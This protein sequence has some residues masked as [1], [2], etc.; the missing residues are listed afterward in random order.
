MSFGL[1]AL[2][3]MTP[4]GPERRIHLLRCST[5][6]VRQFFIDGVELITRSNHKFLAAAIHYRSGSAC[7]YHPSLWTNTSGTLS[8]QYRGY[9]DF[10]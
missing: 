1:R 4:A 3:E 9:L 6:Y 5:G 7:L 10:D 8:G 2:E